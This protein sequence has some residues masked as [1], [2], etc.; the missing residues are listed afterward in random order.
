MDRLTVYSG[1]LVWLLHIG[2]AVAGGLST[3]GQS[4]RSVGMGGAFSALADDG[5]AIF[6]NPAGIAQIDGTTIQA[7]LFY[8]R[9]DI[10]YQASGNTAQHS[11]KSWLGTP[12]FLTRRFTPRLTGGLG[13][14]SPYSRDAEFAADTGSG[15]A[16]QRADIF[17]LDI[18]PVLA[19]QATS[20]LSL[21][22]GAV[23][24]YSEI[25]QSI[26]A[27]AMLR[28]NDKMDGWA[29]GGVVAALY[30]PN[31]Q[32][33]LG[34]TYRS[35][36]TT[37]YAGRRQL[38]TPGPLQED[39]ARADGKWPASASVGILWL[40]SP[41]LKLAFD[42]NWTEWSHVDR[43]VTETDALGS[44]TT[45]LEQRDTWDYRLGA[46]W[47]FEPG[48]FLRGGASR[49]AQATPS[50]RILPS[51]PD[52]DGYTL[53]LGIGRKQ[54]HW[55]FDAAYEYADTDTVHATD[56]A[57]GFTG[58]YH[59]HQHLLVVTAGYRF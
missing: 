33:R 10:R 31:K 12:L 38:V 3:P 43:V 45:L 47:E 52:A 20:R 51:R 1:F 17:R 21:S 7:S 39:N 22:G 36:M 49:I 53:A 23:V 59:I 25:D 35:R 27:G 34:L 16:A 37:D 24:A 14:Y 41:R 54:R 46:E 5:A 28:I 2:S 29:L 15:F 40:P 4:A 9:P 56:N 50:S 42:V 55:S 57:Y 30:A 11:T 26:P 58:D 6:Y 48:W 18:S 44:S 19:Y 8:G 13:V 32:L